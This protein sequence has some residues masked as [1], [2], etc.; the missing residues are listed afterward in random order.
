MQHYS[1]IF[2]E[3][4]RDLRFRTTVLK[5]IMHLRE[6][7]QSLTDANARTIIVLSSTAVASSIVRLLS[8]I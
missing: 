8:A 2:S 3:S 6:R 7:I 1:R 4:S 5:T